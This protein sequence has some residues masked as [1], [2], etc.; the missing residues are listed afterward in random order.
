MRLNRQTLG[1]Y[2]LAVVTIVGGAAVSRWLSAEAGLALVA[3][4][5]YTFGLLKQ[6]PRFVQ[7]GALPQA[8]LSD[9]DKTPVV[10]PR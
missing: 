8:T 6:Q 2:A 4:G 10:G 5:S 3:I 9:D 1:I 7:P